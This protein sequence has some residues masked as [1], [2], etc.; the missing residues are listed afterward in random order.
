ME[1]IDLLRDI[2]LRGSGKKYMTEGWQNEFWQDIISRFYN[3]PW[4][5]MEGHRLLFLLCGQSVLLGVQGR[6]RMRLLQF[7][8]SSQSVDA[9]HRFIVGEILYHT[10]NLLVTLLRLTVHPGRGGG[11]GRGAP[12]GGF[13]AA[14]ANKGAIQNFEGSKLTFNDDDSSSDSSFFSSFFSA[15]GSAAAAAPPAAAPPAAAPAPPAGIEAIFCDPSAIK[16]LM[17]LPASCAT[18]TDARSW[19]KDTPTLSKISFRSDSDGEAFPPK[20]ASM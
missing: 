4:T 12:R 1:A 7:G 10:G 18:T 3:R 5:T 6:P 9:F 16:V 8:P 14:A 11:R 2:T 20:E 13:K 19:S 17:S 15:S